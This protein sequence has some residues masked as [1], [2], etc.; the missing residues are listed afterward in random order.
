MRTTAP[1][2]G[3]KIFTTCPTTLLAQPGDCIRPLKEMA[4]ASEEAG[5]EGILVFTDNAQLDP[6]LVSQIII[7]ATE[8]ISPLVAIQPVY[9][10]PYSVA[11]MITSLAFLHG[12]RLYL[13]MVAGDSRTI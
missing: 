7:E 10:H 6:W 12:R 3:L 2:H 11:K 4:R 9:M 13:N 5:C 1:D 8:R